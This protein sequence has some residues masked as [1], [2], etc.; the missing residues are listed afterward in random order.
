ME[1]HFVWF[2]ML[3]SW[4]DRWVPLA[5][6]VQRFRHV[7]GGPA[8]RMPHS[9]TGHVEPVFPII[10]CRRLVAMMPS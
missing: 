7:P 5:R 3:T 8:I 10:T 9:G 4:G 1:I 6:S 2:S